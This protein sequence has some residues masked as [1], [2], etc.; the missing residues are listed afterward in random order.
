MS[1]LPIYYC[2]DACVHELLSIIFMIRKKK[3]E[4]TFWDPIYQVVEN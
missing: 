3:W 4:V 2:Y 1:V